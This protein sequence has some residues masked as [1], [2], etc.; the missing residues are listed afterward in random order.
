MTTWIQK[1][2]HKVLNS[3]H[4]PSAPWVLGLLSFTESCIFIIP[5][6]V[7]LLPMCYA[8]RKFAWLYAAITT[9]TSV[10][11]AIGGY[12][13]GM[14]IWEEISVYLFEYVP[15]FSQYFEVVGEKYRNNVVW[16][17]FIA[18]FTPIPFK[19]FTVAAGV[20]S[21]KISL[22]T[23]ILTSI[24]GRGVRY[25]I[26][27]GLI[28]FLGERAKVIIEKHFKL[29]TLIVAFLGVA[30]FTFKIITD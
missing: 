24:V 1:L 26:M 27:A 28:F 9:L 7:L 17:L 19:V 11:G 18:A 16:T 25:F 22:I 2:Y 20:Y 21:A 4:H 12:L 6:E 29:F 10:L 23:L 14:L 13:L 3:C 30:V 8:R 15:G 5:P